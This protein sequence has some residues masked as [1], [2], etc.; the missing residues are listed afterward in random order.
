MKTVYKFTFKEAEEILRKE[1]NIKAEDEVEI[2]RMPIVSSPWA[3][4]WT[5]NIPCV[6]T[7]NN[8]NVQYYSGDITP[9]TTA[10][11]THDGVPC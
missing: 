4:N 3:Y 11:N 10:W 9:M 6:T 8:P 1:Y 2:E 5:T 7:T